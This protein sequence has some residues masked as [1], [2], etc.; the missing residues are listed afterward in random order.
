MQGR[1]LG[2]VKLKGEFIKKFGHI[3]S[4]EILESFMFCMNLGFFTFYKM[5]T[6]KWQNIAGSIFF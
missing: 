3:V 6:A 4:K 2:P 5:S 1:N